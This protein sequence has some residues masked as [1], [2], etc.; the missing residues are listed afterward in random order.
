MVHQKEELQQANTSIGKIEKFVG[1]KVTLRIKPTARAH[2]EFS[3]ELQKIASQSTLM[4]Q[5]GYTV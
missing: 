5:F 2:A 1:K 3:P 4:Q